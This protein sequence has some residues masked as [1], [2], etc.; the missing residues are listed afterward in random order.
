MDSYINNYF[1]PVNTIYQI[2]CTLRIALVYV[3]KP[4]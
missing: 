3:A 2:L 4:F 1:R